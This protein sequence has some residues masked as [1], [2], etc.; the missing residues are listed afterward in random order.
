MLVPLDRGL[1]RNVAANPVRALDTHL[2]A[3]TGADIKA[4]V[5]QNAEATLVS[6]RVPARRESVRAPLPVHS[7]VIRQVRA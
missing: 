5:Q 6:I 2:H 7:C 4:V 3:S 1:L